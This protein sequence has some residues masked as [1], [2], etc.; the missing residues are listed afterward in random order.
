MK[1]KNILFSLSI[2]AA[3]AAIVVAGTT[4]FFSDTE[5]SSGNT[6]TAGAI[7]LQIKNQ[8]SYSAIPSYSQDW[9]FKDIDGELYFSFS[10]LKPGDWGENTVTLKV[11]SNDSYVC[12][13]V[14]GVEEENGLVDP[15]LEL[16]DTDASG[17]LGKD[18]RFVWW[19]DDGDNKLED[20]ETILFGGPV[21]FFYMMSVAANDI[22]AEDQLY[23]T[24]TDPTHNI[25]GVVGQ[26]FPGNTEKSLGIGWC[27]GD[28]AIDYTQN[29]GFTCDGTNVS[30]M[31]QT[32]QIKDAVLSFSATQARNNAS[33]TCKD[34]VRGN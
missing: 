21:S 6:F 7:D 25:F 30:N 12:A 17:E 32:D 3:A 15:E 22:Y 27:F 26:A 31:A 23:L 19:V 34:S 2:M 29:A 10:D 28:M 9:G 24:L 8:A 5:T 16:N 14:Y 1:F 33:F 18:L 13:D 11:T 4:A 20:A